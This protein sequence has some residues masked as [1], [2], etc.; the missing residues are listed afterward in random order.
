MKSFCLKFFTIFFFFTGLSQSNEKI[1]YL[2]VDFVLA[3]SDKGK[4]ILSNLEEKNKENIKILQSKEKILKD[5]ETQIIKQKNIIS[6]DSYKEKV[7]NLKNK[8]DIFKKDKDKL[9]KNFNQLRQQEI[10]EFI[11]LVDQILGEYVEKNAIDLVL[12]KKD[13][14]MGKNKYNITNEILELVNKS[15]K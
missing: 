9:V 1:V 10:N 13:I 3:N 6:E 15:N 8:I 7:N 5:Q 14:L 2:D 4:I 11:K 12:N